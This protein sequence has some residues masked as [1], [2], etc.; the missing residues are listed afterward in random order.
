MCMNVA[1][2]HACIMYVWASC[3]CLVPCRGQ[4]VLDPLELEL[5]VI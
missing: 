3:A 1:C 2:L 5:Q 4:K